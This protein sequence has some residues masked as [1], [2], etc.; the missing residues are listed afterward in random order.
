MQTAHAYLDWACRFIRWLIAAQEPSRC[1]NSPRL[2]W[3][4]I[5]AMLLGSITLIG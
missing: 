1:P 5:T 3:A 4:S 2:G